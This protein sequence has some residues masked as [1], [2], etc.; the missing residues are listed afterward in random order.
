MIVVG[1]HKLEI[2]E[3]DPLRL[4]KADGNLMDPVGTAR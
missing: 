2:A 3:L 4:V 1:A